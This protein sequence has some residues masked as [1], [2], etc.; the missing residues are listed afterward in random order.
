MWNRERM[1]RRAL[2]MLLI[3]DV[4]EEEALE[5]VAPEAT[6][7]PSEVVLDISWKGA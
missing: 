1:R 4:A 6:E 5:L 2:T 3:A 7:D